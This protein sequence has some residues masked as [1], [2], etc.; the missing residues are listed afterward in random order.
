[1]EKYFWDEATQ[2]K[3]VVWDETSGG[4]H[5]QEVPKGCYGVDTGDPR[6]LFAGWFTL[7]AEGK[8]TDERW[9]IHND[10]ILPPELWIQGGA[11]DTGDPGTQADW[12][13]TDLPGL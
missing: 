7:D 3:F 10:I 1:M 5:G 8:K 2:P 4:G 11:N 9:W 13:T 6:Y 12:T